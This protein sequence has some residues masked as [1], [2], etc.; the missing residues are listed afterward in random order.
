[1][2]SCISSEMHVCLLMIAHSTADHKAGEVL[3]AKLDA[4]CVATTS[5]LTQKIYPDIQTG[6]QSVA[7]SVSCVIELQVRNT[8]GHRPHF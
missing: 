7:L 6:G 5:N 4:S 1:M 2:F 8:D 3:K